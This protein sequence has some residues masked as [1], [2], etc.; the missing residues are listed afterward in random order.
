M[1]IESLETWP[2]SVPYAHR[3]VSARVDRGGV[4]VV[5]V[6]L[7]ADDGT[8][9]W[10]EACVLA[11]AGA[12]DEILKS[13]RPF[14]LGRD[15]WDIEAV[16]RDFFTTGVWDFLIQAGNLAYAGIDMA[17]W[18]LCGKAA[19]QPLYK[20]LGGALRDEVDYFY[21]LRRGTPDEIAQQCS[22]GVR[23]GYT[24]YYLKVGIDTTEER[25]M[26][27]AIR[28]T[29]G[30]DGKIRVDA[31]QAWTTSEAIRI[32]SDWDSAFGLDFVEAPIQAF[33]VR[34]TADLRSR[35]SVAISYN[36]G[37]GEE[38][39]VLE[40]LRERAADVLCLSSYWVGSV[41]RFMTLSRVAALE[42]VG[43]VKHTHG[44]LGVAAA[45]GQHMMLAIPNAW[46][47]SQHTAMI[48]ADDIITADLPIAYSPTWGLLDLPGLGVEVDEDK[49][50]RYHD[51]YLANGQYMAY[52]EEWTVDRSN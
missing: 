47:G 33:P 38:Q 16:A 48:M 25:E 20:L 27:A 24:C 2:V 31:N 43:I 4:T 28:D 39:R 41:S 15:V 37:L 52:G 12:T 36:E 8:V 35:T 23:A 32:L 18:D 45:V 29:I 40:V 44:E 19:K 26:L 22:E 46:P 34:N 50:Q 6:K 17:M 9:G 5:M 21:Y 49:L 30:R 51:A 7:T 42:D 13:A 10:G 14:V 11:S 1:K 3:E